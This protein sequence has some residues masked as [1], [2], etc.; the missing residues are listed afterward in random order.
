MGMKAIVTDIAAFAAVAGIC[1]AEEISESLK[2][3]IDN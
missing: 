1:A 3:A 2:I